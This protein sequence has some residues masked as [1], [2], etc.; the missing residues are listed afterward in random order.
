MYRSFLIALRPIAT[1]VKKVPKFAVLLPVF[2][3]DVSETEEPSM[4]VE[5]SAS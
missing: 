2:L 4:S 5:G 3:K 1:I